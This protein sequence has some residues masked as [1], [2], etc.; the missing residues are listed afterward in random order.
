MGFSRRVAAVAPAVGDELTRAMVGVGMVFAGEG[1]ECPNIEDTLM[2]A[3]DEGVV[4]EDLRTLSV[5]VRWLEVHHPF[6]NVDRMTRLVRG[7]APGRVS[8]FWSAVARWL[9][10]D[11]RWRRLAD[12]Y[13]GPRVDLL[14][15]GTDFLVRRRGEDPRFAGGPLRVPLQTLRSRRSDVLEPSSLARRHAAYRWRVIIGPTYRADMWAALEAEPSLSAA[16]LAR[17]AYGS[18]ATAWRVRRD[19]HL[20]HGG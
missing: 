8:V 10:N 16:A 7:L 19:W 5:L 15:T 13:A 18:F 12:G 1:A 2:A 17:C 4:A 3:S 11:S 14:S 9:S 20:V 6:V